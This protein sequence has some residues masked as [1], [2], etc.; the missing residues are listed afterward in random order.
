MNQ[1]LK[2]SIENS[3]N[4]SADST[5]TIDPKA[6]RPSGR[7]INAEALNSL[8][9]GPSD[10]DLMKESIAAILSPQIALDSKL[11]AFDNF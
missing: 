7:P 1:L 2:W 9:G 10:A 5:S 8:F 6:E 4:P 3:E 11:V